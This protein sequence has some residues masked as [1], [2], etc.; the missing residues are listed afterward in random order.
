[1]RPG[2]GGARQNEVL[3]LLLTVMVSAS[4]VACGPRVGTKGTMPP[5]GANGL[6]DPSAVPDF[7][8]VAGPDGIAGYVQKDAVLAMQD[9]AWPVYGEDL[10]T[11]VGQL[12]PGVG[13]V[14]IDASPGLGSRMPPSAGPVSTGLSETTAVALYVR[15][16]SSQQAWV[17]FTDGQVITPAGAFLG[18]G[19]L[20]S[21]CFNV[22][23]RSRL[24]L[25]DREPTQAGALVVATAFDSAVDDQTIPR[26]VD[27]ASDGRIFIGTGIPAWW[28]S[29]PPPC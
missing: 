20:G 25:L 19:L 13:F 21:G 1:M 16:A 15:N 28:V 22:P 6:V 23:L 3:S 26:S 17:A 29:D 18:G 27:I 8:A 9:R 4:V 24:V 2:R 10:T 14:P 12:I 7:V 11:V 5:P